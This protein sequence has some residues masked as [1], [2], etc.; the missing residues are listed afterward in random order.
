MHPILEKAI[1]KAERV[2]GEVYFDARVRHYYR[3][4]PCRLVDPIIWLRRR[5]DSMQLPRLRKL[6]EQFGGLAGF[7]A[8]AGLPSGTVRAWSSGRRAMDATARAYLELLDRLVFGSRSKSGSL[9]GLYRVPQPVGPAREHCP[10]CGKFMPHKKA[11]VG[12]SGPIAA[13]APPPSSAPSAATGDR[14]AGG[15]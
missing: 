3:A 2:L 7:A 13:V 4:L 11:N 12:A 1:A 9:D 10:T 14:K 6:A 15:E 5:T 8:I